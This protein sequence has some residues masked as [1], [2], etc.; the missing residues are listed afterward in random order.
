MKKFILIFSVIL[1][2]CSNILSVEGKTH[3]SEINFE[4]NEYIEIYSDDFLNLSNFRLYD[5][6]GINKSNELKEIS[7][8]S[9][10]KYFLI[11]SENFLSNENISSLNCSI[12]SNKK[13]ELGYYGL[14]NNG[15]NITIYSNISFSNMSTNISNFS[16]NFIKLEDLN[17]EV[18]ESLSFN[19]QNNSYFISEKSI[20]KGFGIF[21][22]TI[23][24][25]SIILTIS[26]ESQNI[27]LINFTEEPIFEN[28]STEIFENISFDINLS[29]INT[30]ELN[31]TN[32]IN[33][34]NLC[35]YSF[36]IITSKEIFTDK[37]K[38]KFKT[39]SSNFTIEYFISDFGG[40]ILKEKKN[41]TSLGEK[42]FSFDFSEILIIKATLYTENNC[43]L[44]ASKIV[45]GYSDNKRENLTEVKSTEKKLN[46]TSYISILNKAKIEN[47]STN[48]LEYEIYRGNTTKR[49][50]Y[51]YH[52]NK[53]INSFE[54]EKYSKISG[55]IPFDKNLGNNSIKILG[56]EIETEVNFYP[57][58]INLSQ[59]YINK[60]DFMFKDY[61]EFVNFSLNN[62]S[63]VL[64]EINSSFDYDF[65]C[66]VYFDKTVVSDI[67]NVS[68]ISNESKNNNFSLNLDNLKIK[69]KLKKTQISLNL[70]QTEKEL[71]L[72][73][74][75][76]Y[77]KSSLKTYNSLSY[78]FNFSLDENIL[79]ESFEIENEKINQEKL[80]I[81]S[82][83]TYLSYFN[84]S[85]SSIDFKT[86]SNF[87]NKKINFNEIQVGVEKLNQASNKNLEV[88]SSK[89]IFMKENSYF[90]LFL[91]SILILISLISI[92]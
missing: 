70:N 30:N 43:I 89:N 16:L 63:R 19:L 5:E 65:I 55:K 92:W 64:F 8:V 10:S 45:Y 68:N 31:S 46:E 78:F 49:T 66:Y 52:N 88:Y 37:I 75:C 40:E 12:Y 4:E 85:T 76:K 20:C 38:Y 7:L 87:E 21:S 39:N 50:I 9:D 74:Y 77:K 15:E 82:N 6:L 11:V 83:M 62:Y 48:I 14:K 23:P 29:A 25:S 71:E 90:A 36:E 22:D 67:L 34:T 61:F 47:L 58:E 18:N 53:K 84:N 27:S 57:P 2:L 44:N 72:K 32:L 28:I 13:S 33:Q 86:L 60:S 41:T 56:F 81:S 69:E 1:V 91:G 26:N 51:F 79:D 54:V 42:S 35:N 24:N 3:I 80:R 73:L 17:F 59:N